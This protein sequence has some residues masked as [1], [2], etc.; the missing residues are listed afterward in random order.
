MNHQPD[1]A[2]GALAFQ[3]GY[4]VLGQFNVFQGAPGL[5]GLPGGSKK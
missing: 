3:S 5:P 1:S 4:Q 2:Q